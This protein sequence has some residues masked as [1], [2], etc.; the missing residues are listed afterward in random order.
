M[1]GICPIHL[2]NLEIHPILLALLAMLLWSKLALSGNGLQTVLR[3]ILLGV[4]LLPG[5]TR[6]A[7]FALDGAD[8]ARFEMESKKKGPAYCERHW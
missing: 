5:W 2:K 4:A 8:E 6:L 7:E 3:F 1:P